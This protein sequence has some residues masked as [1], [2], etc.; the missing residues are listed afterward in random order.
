MDD[1]VVQALS[2]LTPLTV[3][4]RE[5]WRGGRAVRWVE[6]GSA[7]LAVICDASLGEPG[8]LAWAGLMSIVPPAGRVVAYDRAGIGASD[9]VER[10]TLASQV[11]DLIAVIRETAS[12]P[13]ILVGHSLGGVLVQL[14]ALRCPELV[15]GLVLVDPAEEQYLATL[16]PDELRQGIALGES[17]ISQQADGTL[18]GTV[19]DTFTG[20]AQHLSGDP[21]VQAL[22][23][24][25]YVSCYAAPSQARVVRDEHEMIF[26][27]LSTIRRLRAECTLPDV[28]VVVL[29]ATTG[30]PEEQRRVWT[31]HH[32]ALAAS[33]PRGRHVVLAETSHAINQER[34]P[35]VADAIKSVIDARG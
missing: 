33:V 9:P 5:L 11:D 31:S 28:P 19:R 23:L 22:I 12:Q 30:R 15:A 18:P 1:L 6:V 26:N 10:P 32:A 34:A 8:S 20:H 24:D 21:Q 29:S 14:A 35:A 13:S 2:A 27:S 3:R 4:R 25:A 16:P 7:G 17:V